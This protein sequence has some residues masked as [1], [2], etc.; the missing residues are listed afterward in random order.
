MGEEWC[1]L[2][3]YSPYKETG[4]G[5]LIPHE[6]M[7]FPKLLAP[8]PDYQ[9]SGLMGQTFGSGE[10][11]KRRI[12]LPMQHITY[13]IQPREEARRFLDQRDGN[14]FLC[15]LNYLEL[16]SVM[17]KN[18]VNVFAYKVCNCYP[19]HRIQSFEQCCA[20]W[21]TTYVN[22]ENKS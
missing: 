16:D 5:S 20:N 21:F 8:G 2:N 18:W 9:C 22:I 17:M 15:C 13:V 1:F 7:V 12:Y 3:I 14:W 6:Q 19:L 4:S 10:K 11:A